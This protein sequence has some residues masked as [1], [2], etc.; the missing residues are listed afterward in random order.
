MI[1]HGVDIS[2]WQANLDVSTLPVDF[3]IVKATEG[4]GFVD[5]LCDTFVQQAISSGKLWGFYHYAQDNDPREEARFFVENTRGYFN[6]GIPILDIEEEKISSWGEW[7][8]LWV[9]EVERLTGVC[10]MIY[11]SASK[12]A[13]FC[14]TDLPTRCGLWVAGYPNSADVWPIDTTIP[15][16]L[17]PWAFAAIWQFTDALDLGGCQLDG[18]FAYMDCRAWGLYAGCFTD[19]GEAPKKEEWP[20]Y[21][22]E[23]IAAQVTR[24][25]WGNGAE[26]RR[27]LEVAGYNYR[28]VQDYVERLYL[29]AHDVIHGDYGNGDY[30]VTRLALAGY[31]PGVVQEI[32]NRLM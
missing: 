1:M 24:G 3:V 21:P 18:D 28:A 10:P 25:E 5:Q 14:G 4:L 7:A 32:V 15:Y 11:A 17:S 29:V 30:R 20:F 19:E 8:Q 9:D 22:V 23:A 2:N 31:D 12:L 13:R 26:R 6:H 16:D 27:R